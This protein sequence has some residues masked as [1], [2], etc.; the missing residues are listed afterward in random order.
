MIDLI[1]YVA[2]RGW[3]VLVAIVVVVVCGHHHWWRVVVVNRRC[4]PSL[5]GFRVAV[6]VAH[7]NGPLVCHIRNLVVATLA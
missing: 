2:I 5:W 1:E 4:R 7:L 3:W 6:D